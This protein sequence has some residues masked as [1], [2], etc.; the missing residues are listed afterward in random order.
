MSYKLLYLLL[1]LSDPPVVSNFEITG[2]TVPGE[3]AILT[4]T[5]DGRPLTS[6]QIFNGTN[7]LTE[8]SAENMV[9]YTIKKV[10]CL[11]SGTFQCVVT[12]E[13]YE[14]PG[15]AEEDLVAHCKDTLLFMDQPWI[16][17]KYV[18]IS[19]NPVPRLFIND[20]VNVHALYVC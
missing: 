5:G 6:A 3:H 13:E 12:N 11:H 8:E 7:K 15:I 1:V 14:D 17:N 10:D 18:F 16:I 9:E 20:Q 4:C 19:N 2:G